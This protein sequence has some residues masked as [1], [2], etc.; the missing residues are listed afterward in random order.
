LFVG[1]FPSVARSGSAIRVEQC[2]LLRVKQTC[3]A[4]TA[5]SA[6]DPKR[7]SIERLY[8]AGFKPTRQFRAGTDTGSMPVFVITGAADGD[9]RNLMRALPSA[10]CWAV[11]DMP[12][13]NTVTF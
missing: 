7:T 3:S 12:A 5:T 4:H 10:G 2:P 13:E 6:F 9:E 11:A 1:L 8:G